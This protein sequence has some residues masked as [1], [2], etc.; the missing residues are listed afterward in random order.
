MI[1]IEITNKFVDELVAR[2]RPINK[3]RE[4]NKILILLKELH[5]EKDSDTLDSNVVALRRLG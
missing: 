3:R 5:D 2:Y 4:L 1:P